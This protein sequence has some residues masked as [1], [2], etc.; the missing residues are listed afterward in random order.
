MKSRRLTDGAERTYILV[1]EPGEEAFDA[2]SRFAVAE[3]IDAASVTAIGAFRSAVLAFYDLENRRYDEIPVDRQTEVLSFIGDITLDEHE[4]PHPHL[5]A[6]LGLPD[7]STRGGH[8]MKGVVQ[9]TLEV[10]VRETPAVL[11]RT[12][13]ADLGLALIDPEKG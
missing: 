1:V 4:K 9:P 11:R 5:H 2:I 13:R 12:F 7:G 8:F 10:I 3:R 6:V